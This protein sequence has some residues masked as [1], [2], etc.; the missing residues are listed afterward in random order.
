M[1]V[2]GPVKTLRMMDIMEL[3]I[4]KTKDN[5]TFRIDQCVDEAVFV[6]RVTDESG[7]QY[8]LRRNYCY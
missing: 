2:P 4:R 1:S 8:D 5:D 3:D 7:T 6:V